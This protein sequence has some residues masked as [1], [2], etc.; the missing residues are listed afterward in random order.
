MMKISTQLI[1]SSIVF[2]ST[3]LFLLP[4]AKAQID[5]SGEWLDQE[6]NWNQPGAAIPEAPAQ[7]GNNLEFCE[8]TIRQAVLPED[9]LVEAAGWTLTGSARIYDATTVL[10]G[11]ANADGM[12]R[13]YNYQVFVFTDGV[14]TGTLSPIPMNS[15]S[16]GSLFDMDLYR[17]GY[18]DASFNRYKPSDALCC[19]SAESRVFYTVEMQD[20]LPVLVPRLP[21]DTMERPL[22]E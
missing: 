22:P 16:D 2:A 7:A 8:H 9:K 4:S 18:I 20:D 1:P 15:R 21:A 14:F 10:M 12:C 13:P 3:V 5:V 17:E 11:T 6:T 19:A